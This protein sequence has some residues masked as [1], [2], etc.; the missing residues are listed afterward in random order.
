MAWISA[1]DAPWMAPWRGV[2]GGRLSA[3]LGPPRN[4]TGRAGEHTCGEGSRCLG[5]CLRDPF[6]D[7]QKMGKAFI[8]GWKKL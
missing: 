6:T 2:P 3:G 4:T 1:M 8:G 7:K 5:C